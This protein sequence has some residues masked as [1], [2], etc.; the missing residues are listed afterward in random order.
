[1]D[2]PCPEELTVI[3]VVQ[4]TQVYTIV[5]RKGCLHVLYQILFSFFFSLRLLCMAAAVAVSPFPPP[6]EAHP[7]RLLQVEDRNI[8]HNLFTDR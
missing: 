3:S 6:P 4:Y 1:M 5:P 2:E 7:K 8:I